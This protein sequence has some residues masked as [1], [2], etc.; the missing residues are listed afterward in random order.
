MAR[1]GIKHRTP[2]AMSI[3]NQ[4]T[5]AA[6][7]INFAITFIYF[8][9]KS[10][11]LVFCEGGK[12]LEIDSPDGA[13]FDTSKTYHITGLKMREYTFR[14]IKSRLRVGIT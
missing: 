9:K 11:L 14:S 13:E 6:Y 3:F 2:C 10:T 5:I 4:Y 12:V 1:P 7:I 8:Q